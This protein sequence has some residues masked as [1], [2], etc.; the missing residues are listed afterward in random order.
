MLTGT[1]PV[2]VPLPRQLKLVRL[3]VAEQTAGSAI[4]LVGN[5]AVSKGVASARPYIQLT[6]LRHCCT[7][8]GYPAFNQSCTKQNPELC[9]IPHR[10]SAE[11]AGTSSFFSACSPE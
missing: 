8:R 6:E 5:Q 9:I 10:T 7:S 4:I 11:Q 3:A 1:I 2:V